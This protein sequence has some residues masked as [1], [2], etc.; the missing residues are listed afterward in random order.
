M[1]ITKKEG[2]HVQ[3]TISYTV[4]PVHDVE[5]FV[6]LSGRLKD[7]G[8][9]S[10]CIKDMAGICKP[11]VGAELVKGIIS[12][13]GLPVQ[14]HTHYTSGMGSMLYLK[15][16]EAGASVVDTAASSMALSTSQPST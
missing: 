4:S 9:D 13:T 14:V 3:G 1:E 2:A 6:D 15:C 5:Y 7:L 16:I 8:A 10:I 11:Y 12:A